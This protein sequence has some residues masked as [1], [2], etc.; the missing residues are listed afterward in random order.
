MGLRDLDSYPPQEPF[1][2]IGAKYHVRVQELGA[3]ISGE[4]FAYGDDPYQEV[5]VFA[6]PEPNGTVVAFM[7]GGG[8]TN[9]YKEWM[10]FMAPALTAAG[11]TFVSIGYRLAPAVIWP[12]GVE[13]AAAGIAWVYNNIAAHGGDPERIFVGGHSAGGHQAA[14]LAVRSDWQEAAGVPADVI[15][16]ALPVSGVYDFTEGNGMPANPRFLGENAGNDTDASPIHTMTNTPP[17]LMAWGDRDFPHLI[18][19]AEK[20]ARAL[21][22]AGGTVK[23]V[24]LSD[25]DHLGSSYACGH[26]EGLWVGSLV[27]WVSNN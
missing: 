6:A 23:T 1:S 26:A 20:M 19:Q 8:W 27:K 15:R 13:D 10:A 21:Q 25:C 17:F 2:D 18:V 11:I 24:S 12:A 16:G 14:W 4:S 7:H 9:G 22:D 5:A 3:G